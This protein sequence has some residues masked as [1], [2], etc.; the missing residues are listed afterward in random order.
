MCNMCNLANLP[1]LYSNDNNMYLGE[2]H[3]E[4]VDRGNTV[5]DVGV[6][7]NITRPSTA[8]KKILNV[9]IIKVCISF[10]LIVDHLLVN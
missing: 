4:N 9:L 7:E 10:T 1:F 6:E 2:A 5:L 3:A 8:C